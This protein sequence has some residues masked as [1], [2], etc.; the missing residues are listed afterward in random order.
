MPV[1]SH[2][3]LVANLFLYFPYDMSKR[4]IISPK[5]KDNC[6]KC[7][8]DIFVSYFPLHGIKKNEFSDR[9]NEVYLPALLANYDRPTDKPTDRG[10]LWKIT[11]QMSGYATNNWRLV[12]GLNNL[13]YV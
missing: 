2:Q 11:L 10:S 7:L 1:I 3:I 4:I 5:I 9:N 6:K 13:S 12:T 8:E